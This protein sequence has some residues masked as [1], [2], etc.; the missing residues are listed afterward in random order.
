MTKNDW[1]DS[2]GDRVANIAVYAIVIIGAWNGTGTVIVAS[3][4]SF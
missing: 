2:A 3:S 4:P 1:G